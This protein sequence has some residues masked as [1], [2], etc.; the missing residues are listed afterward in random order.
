MPHL[1][2]RYAESRIR[3]S[4]TFS[5]IVGVLGQRQ[6]GKTT[7]LEGFA[8]SYSTFDRE[9]DLLEAETHPELFLANRKSPFAIDESQLCPRIFPALKESVRLT[10]T[11][12]QFLLSGSVRFTSREIIRES[13]TGRIVNIELLPFSL[14]EAHGLP[15]PSVLKRLFSVKKEHDLQALYESQIHRPEIFST[16]L[17]TGGLPGIAFFRDKIIRK[18]KFEA[19]IDTL[20]NRD[21][22]LV[23]KTTL[24]Y[25]QLRSLM[26]YLAI[27]QGRSLELK[28][29]S[30]Y[31]QISTVTLKR[32]LFAFEA[33]YLIR[34][35][36]ALKG[37][38]KKVAYFLEDQGMATWLL[39]QEPE[40]N[41]NFLRGI[42][43]NLR[44][45]LYY[46]PSSGGSVHFYRTRHG[47]NV[48]LV[49]DTEQGLLGIIPCAD[50]TPPAKTLGSALAFLKKFQNSRVVI[51]V[52]DQV[53]QFK[54]PH[55]FFIP[56]YWLV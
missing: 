36:T 52:N 47:V 18:E 46:G 37:G 7:L 51:A 28:D 39:R 3:K 44:Q 45:E 9:S 42:Y 22:R 30:D 8:K 34:P 24:I 29:A 17:E 41:Y 32:I 25:S 20:L 15:E 40:E 27:H 43:S 16:Y 2:P 19:Q 5:P 49:F 48:P 14:R 23:V 1:R 35:V 10:K 12:G 33:L 31:S 11:P 21:I 56:Y 13:L 54:Q 38:E 26:K 55:L 6:V 4:L 50:R 53:P